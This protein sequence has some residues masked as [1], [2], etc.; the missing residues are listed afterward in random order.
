VCAVH[1]RAG[2]RGNG[3][4]IGK[5]TNGMPDINRWQKENNTYMQNEDF[6]EY[7]GRSAGQTEPWGVGAESP[8]REG[9]RLTVCKLIVFICIGVFLYCDLIA[10]ESVLNKFYGVAALYGPAVI[11]GGEYYRLLSYMF[12]HMGLNHVANNM[13]L[14]FF[15]GEELERFFG[16]WR[17][18]FLYFSSGI[19]AGIVSIVYNIMSGNSVSSVGASGAG[20]GLIGAT[21]CLLLA[22]KRKRGTAFVKRVILFAAISLYAG[23]SEQGIDNAA[24]VG[25]FLAGAAVTALLIVIRRHRSES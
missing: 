12:L 13:I 14:I 19:V 4:R 11:Q 23:F 21:V 24:H 6:E 10:S 7:E 17:F 18:F 20:F 3:R 8:Q 9:F 2:K 1:G 25:G 15:L 5:W 16:K 22:D